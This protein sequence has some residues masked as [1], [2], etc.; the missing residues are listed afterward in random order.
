MTDNFN[1][2]VDN[3]LNIYTSKLDDRDELVKL[4]ENLKNNLEKNESSHKELN[5]EIN[6]LN[7]VYG[8]TMKKNYRREIFFG[9][10][11]VVL[12]FVGCIGT[13][14]Y[15]IM[16]KRTVGA[17]IA[18]AVIFI[19][20]VSFLIISGL[21]YRKIVDVKD[22]ILSALKRQDTTESQHEKLMLVY[23]MVSRQIDV[24]MYKE[25]YESIYDI[26]EYLKENDK[27]GFESFC[28]A[29]EALKINLHKEQK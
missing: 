19:V 13:I 21:Y 9:F 16:T 15:A 22:A 11:S 25:I 8:T 6:Q 24:L 10:M 5:N 4:A 1:E 7:K 3:A 18:A 17:I 20:S 29:A 23:G 12:L 26:Q 14:T 28:K 2:L 27:S